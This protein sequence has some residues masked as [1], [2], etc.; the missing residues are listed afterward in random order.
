MSRPGR[1]GLSLWS[2]YVWNWVFQSG[3]PTE[4]DNAGLDL[5]QRGAASPSSVLTLGSLPMD[6]WPQPGSPTPDPPSPTLISVCSPLPGPQ[7]GL[8][9]LTTS[10]P[11]FRFNAG[12]VGAS[13]L[14]NGLWPWCSGSW[15]LF[16]AWPLIYHSLKLSYLLPYL[17][18][19]SSLWNASSVRTGGLPVL[20]CG[21]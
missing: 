15:V 16:L 10:A 5:L 3:S 2:D 1:K 12:S 18:S 11:K 17:L 7:D 4:K 8:T 9:L 19:P 21:S 14:L 20:Y 13:H 6:S